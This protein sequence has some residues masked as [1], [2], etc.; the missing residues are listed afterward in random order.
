MAS[1]PITGKTTK[2]D[3][4]TKTNIKP[5]PAPGVLLCSV[6]I[7]PIPTNIKAPKITRS[8]TEPKI[9]LPMS[10]AIV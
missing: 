6:N 1:N 3:I 5:N 4:A 9:T 2:T 10:P 7:K 8:M